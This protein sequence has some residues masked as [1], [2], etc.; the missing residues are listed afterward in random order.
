MAVSVRPRQHHHRFAHLA[1]AA[2]TFDF[3]QNPPGYGPDFNS[4]YGPPPGQPA[5]TCDAC[6]LF[7]S[8]LP[9]LRHF[10]AS[11]ADGS[12]VNRGIIVTDTN[13]EQ[14]A[15]PNDKRVALGISIPAGTNLWHG[16]TNRVSSTPGDP[17]AGTPVA[18][19][20]SWI[21]GPEWRGSVWVVGAA[22]F[23]IDLRVLEISS[24]PVP[25]NLS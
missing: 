1:D 3:P 13:T 25:P 4:D 17:N 5:A 10:L 12:G 14:I 24:T 21:Y 22:P 9:E 16:Y 7:E 8:I 15:W 20:T 23:S 11:G 18:P 19:G 2:D 6:A